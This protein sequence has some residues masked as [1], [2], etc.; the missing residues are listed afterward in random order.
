MDTRV[1]PLRQSK[2]YG[3]VY[4]V[5]DTIRDSFILELNDVEITGR[6][7]HYPNCLFEVNKNHITSLLIICLVLTK[8]LFVHHVTTNL[9]DFLNNRNI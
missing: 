6:N 7:L 9:Q 3:N 2:D 8:L 4:P 1:T 5:N